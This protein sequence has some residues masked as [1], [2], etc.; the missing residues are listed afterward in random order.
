MKERDI[1]L[2]SQGAMF[3]ATDY[4]LTLLQFPGGPCQ[5]S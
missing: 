2:L 5:N 4:I 3:V 1:V